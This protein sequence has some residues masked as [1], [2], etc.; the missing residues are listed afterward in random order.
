MK[1]NFKISDFCISDADIPKD[2]ANKILKFHLMPLQAV[3]DKLNE[4][5]YDTKI[6]KVWAS[7]K[8]CY[9]HYA[10]ELAR[11]RSGKSQHCFLNDSK[12]ATDVTCTN[13][14]RNKD[15]LLEVLIS[16]TEYTR[17]AIYDGFI[18]CDYK[19]QSGKKQLFH[20]TNSS[21]WN[22]IKHV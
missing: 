4:F 7:Q 13:F 14:A 9:R 1:L 18:H 19:E 10:W 8:S 20:S 3:R 17:F 16:E 15:K 12:G 11:G 5:A 2:V 22:F 6:I 21:K